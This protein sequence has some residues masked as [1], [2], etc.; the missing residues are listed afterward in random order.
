MAVAAAARGPRRPVV[1]A[2]QVAPEIAAEITPHAVDVVAVVLRAV[3]LDQ[4]QRPLD[5][6]IVRPPALGAAGPAEMDL[7]D[8]AF[9]HAGHP[10]GRE[11]RL[12]SSRIDFDELHELRALAVVELRGGDAGGFHRFDT[13]RIASH[14]LAVSLCREHRRAALLRAERR[15]QLA[16]FVFFVSEDAQAFPGTPWHDR[17]VGAEEARRVHGRAVAGQREVERQ[18]MPFEAPAPGRAGVRPAVYRHVVAL[19]IAHEA[20]GLDL[21]Q[22][23]FE[24]DDV[25]YLR[26]AR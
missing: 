5:A 19:R 21:A 10:R 24:L 12:E 14:Y 9:P 16:G 3:V 20:K 23:Q 15:Q 7:L 8:A 22:D 18:V 13:L 2:Q 25:Y 17:R 4:E 11:A 26:V 6:V 1:I